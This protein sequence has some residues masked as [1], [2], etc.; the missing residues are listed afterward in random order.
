MK[1]ETPA[2]TLRQGSKRLCGWGSL[3]ILFAQCGTHHIFYL[4][5]MVRRRNRY[6]DKRCSYGKKPILPK[7]KIVTTLLLNIKLFSITCTNSNWLC[8]FFCLFL[9]SFGFSQLFQLKI[10]LLFSDTLRP[11]KVDLQIIVNIFQAVIIHWPTSSLKRTTLLNKKVWHPAC[12]GQRLTWT[13]ATSRS[14]QIQVGFARV[15]LLSKI[16]WRKKRFLAL[17]LDLV[18]FHINKEQWRD[19]SK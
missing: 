13:I 9:F 7:V 2:L 11:H 6:T 10:L 17:M 19:F 5:R 12:E 8:C 18:H 3:R 4:H 16:L 1:D 15:Y 14:R